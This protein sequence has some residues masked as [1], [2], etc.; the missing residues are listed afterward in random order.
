MSR[1]NLRGGMYTNIGSNSGSSF[2]DRAKAFDT[3]AKPSRIPNTADRLAS[4]Q[5]S[6][7]LWIQEQQQLKINKA[8]KAAADNWL[9]NLTK[10]RAELDSKGEPY[11]QDDEDDAIDY[12][13]I[14]QQ[15]LQYY[16]A[17]P[18]K[19]QTE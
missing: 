3:K 7:N 14:F 9:N 15:A 11:Y 8:A 5:A 19:I 6:G 13:K 10:E 4:N 18:N 17:N 1:R 2:A 16:T 12:Q